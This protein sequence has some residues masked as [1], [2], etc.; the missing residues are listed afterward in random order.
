MVRLM[1]YGVI[2]IRN[3]TSHSGYR[4]RG[5]MLS[6]SCTASVM[7]VRVIMVTVMTVTHGTGNGYE[8]VK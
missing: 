2:V 8:V 7:M 4:L 1:S 5:V 3:V 6:V